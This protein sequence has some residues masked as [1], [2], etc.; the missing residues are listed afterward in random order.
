MAIKNLHIG[1]R[2]KWWFLPYIRCLAFFCCVFNRPLD[3]EKLMKVVNG[4]VVFSLK[5]KG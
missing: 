5:D 3:P 1:V 4:A 2:F